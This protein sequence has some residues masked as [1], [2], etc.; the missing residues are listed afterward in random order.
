[1]KIAL[2]SSLYT[3]YVRGGAEVVAE[4]VAHGLVRAGHQVVVITTTPDRHAGRQ[5]EETVDGIR[6]IR[7][8]PIQL[9]PFTHIAAQPLWKRALAVLLDLV[10]IQN[11]RTV[12]SI[13]RDE[14][15][16]LVL[17]HNLKGMGYTIPRAIKS[18]GIRHIHT[19]HDVQLA[20]PS[21]V[22]L[23]DRE[24]LLTLYAPL[25]ALCRLVVGSPDEVV[26]PSLWLL[27]FYESFG[28]FSRSRRRAIPNPIPE[29][30]LQVRK[31][32]PRTGVT[33]YAIIGQL[34][35]HKGVE[36]ALRTF[37]EFAHR[38]GDVHLVVVGQGSLYDALRFRYAEHPYVTIM[39][40]V[41][42]RELPERIYR[43]V[44]YVIVPTLC[45]E[46]SP[47]VIY[48]SL[49]TGT[50]V[51]AADIGGTAELLKQSGTGYIV[52]PGDA[53]ELMQALRISREQAGHSR[54]MGEHGRLYVE[55]MTVDRY[56]TELISA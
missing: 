17:T 21:G 56:I 11:A 30:L 49:A 37:N 31:E 29:E 53:H 27:Q 3:P 8:R 7:F 52:D 45:Y 26:S 2:L 32:G 41:P 50:P 39:G 19:L 46:N 54:G 24:W 5:T 16:D 40:S 9:Y 35:P 14:R 12:R 18:L 13:L 51:I 44:E 20:M 4:R 38:T 10:C 43:H 6:V 42:A 15:P 55:Q 23:L 1:M 34:E 48:E 25:R 36:Y 22:L 47:T 28:F 33:R